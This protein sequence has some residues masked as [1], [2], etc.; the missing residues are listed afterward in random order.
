MFKYYLENDLEKCTSKSRNAGLLRE[1]YPLLTAAAWVF[2]HRPFQELCL[3]RQHLIGEILQAT[4]PGVWEEPNLT[5]TLSCIWPRLC[6][7]DS[8]PVNS[9]IWL[10]GLSLRHCNP[11]HLLTLPPNVVSN[12]SS[13]YLSIHPSLHYGIFHSS[14][15]V[16]NPLDFQFK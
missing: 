4:H 13:I 14:S 5:W 10:D 3:D 2:A 12:K 11:A 16:A 15:P 8:N 6:S 1:T 7:S 9:G